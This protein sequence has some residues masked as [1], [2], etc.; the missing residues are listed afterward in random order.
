MGYSAEPQIG[1][2][3]LIFSPNSISFFCCI[4][5]MS[6][7]VVVVVVFPTCLFSLDRKMEK[8][9]CATPDLPKIAAVLGDRSLVQEAGLQ[10]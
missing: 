5:N 8:C 10:S 1:L 7:V 6:F 4:P 2:A 3:D 9:C